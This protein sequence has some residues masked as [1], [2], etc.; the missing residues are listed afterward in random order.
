MTAPRRRP[1]SP[2]LDAT[3]A[4]PSADVHL[5]LTAADYDRAYQ[6]ASRTRESIPDLLR[7]EARVNIPTS[8]LDDQAT[9][10]NPARFG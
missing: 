2:P 10:A 6:P 5:R 8:M 9:G 4:A 3:A 1:G 7:G